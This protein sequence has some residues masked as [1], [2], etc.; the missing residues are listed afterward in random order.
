MGRYVADQ[1]KNVMM[2][3]SGTYGTTSGTGQWLGLVTNLEPNESTNVINLRYTSTGNRNVS[4]FVQTAK[5]YAP[6][7]TFHPQDWRLLGYTLG[8]IVDGGSPSPYTH[9]MVETN[10]NVG[11]A[12]TS[13]V[14]NPFLSFTIE[15]A[16]QFNPTGLNHVKTFK[17]CMVNTY[18]LNATEG[19]ILEAE[20]ST[21]AREMEYSSGATTA[22]SESTTVP[23]KWS[24][25]F[26][27]LPSG[28]ALNFIRDWGIT[29]NNNLNA[30]H[31]NNGSQ[32]IGTPIPENRDYEI[33]MTADADSGKAKTF[34]DQYY[35]GGST[36][37]MLLTISAAAGS[38]EAFLTFSGCTLTDMPDP[39]A[40]E[41]INQWSLTIAP[42][43]ASVTVNDLTYKYNPW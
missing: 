10:S 5:D 42:Q 23:Y 33:T 30:P 41:G 18:T 25:C 20:V 26:W 24:D 40:N 29:I 15:N 8:S 21:I 6:T 36:F 19:G 4:K 11:N 3:E 32:E 16:K 22:V 37:N 38:Q 9:A 17:G 1:N 34:Y 2:F 27:T 39:T 28:A 35:Q 13:G 12:Y 43:K 31:Y 14:A 7:I